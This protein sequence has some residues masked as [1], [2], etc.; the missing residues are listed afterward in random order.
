MSEMYATKAFLEQTKGHVERNFFV[1]P[2][3][4]ASRLWRYSHHPPGTL[5]LPPPI[6]PE[7]IYMSSDRYLFGPPGMKLYRSPLY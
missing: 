4:H 2:L 3:Q 1:P 7:D 5:Q 6:H